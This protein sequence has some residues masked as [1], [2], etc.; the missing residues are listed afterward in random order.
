M[1]QITLDA[2]K[3]G[4]RM[5]VLETQSFNA[6]TISFYKKNGFEIIGFD[7]YAYSNRGPEEKNMR[8]EARN[9]LMEKYGYS[10]MRAG[11]D[12][13]QYTTILFNPYY[14]VIDW[15]KS[16]E[17]DMGDYMDFFISDEFKKFSI[18]GKY[19]YEVPYYNING[20]EDYQTNYLLAEAYFDNVIAP[21]KKLF[22]M[23]DTTHGLLESKSKMFSEYV[24]KIVEMR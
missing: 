15:M 7:R 2:E 6:R 21:D 1:E 14:S 18:Q 17:I 10:M 13:N 3:S 22:I 4:A 16:F 23:E 19:Y 9:F 24:H 11:S 8:T 20:N 12:Y 5:I